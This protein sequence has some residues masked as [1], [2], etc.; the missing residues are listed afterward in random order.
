MF[1]TQTSG[2]PH[3]AGGIE[4]AARPRAGEAAR[5]VHEIR[6]SDLPHPSRDVPWAVETP[7]W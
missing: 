1:L 7:W 6:R 4:T 3:V 5:D 2:V